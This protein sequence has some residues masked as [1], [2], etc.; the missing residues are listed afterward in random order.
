[1]A[2]KTS[3]KPARK[4]AA[5]KTAAVHKPAAAP[6]SRVSKKNLKTDADP[7]H[8]GAGAPVKLRAAEPSSAI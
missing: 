6:V 4:P 1:M 2:T 7:P 5:R 8:G 3:S